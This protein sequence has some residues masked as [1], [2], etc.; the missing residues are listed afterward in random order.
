V[1]RGRVDLAIDGFEI[2]PGIWVGEGAEIDPDAVLTGPLCIGSYAK[3][4]AG[5]Q[6]GEY[7]VLGH[8]VLVNEGALLHRAVVHDNVVIGRQA[9]L[10][11]CVVGKSSD[12]LRAAAVEE[13]VVIGDHCTIEEEA[14]LGNDVKVYPYKTI[15][16][17]AVVQGSVIWESRGQRPLFGRHGVTGLVNVEITP[18][19]CVRIAAAYAT[20]ISKG[21]VV[22]IGR[23]ASRAGRALERAVVGALTAAAIEVRDLETATM[24]LLRYDVRTSAA[25]GGIL[26]RTTAGDPQS[27]DLVFLDE[28]GDDLSAAARGRLERLYSRGEFR[29]AF[30]GEIADV[31]Y[32][33]RTLE[34]YVQ[35]LLERIDVRGVREANPR[36]V[37][38]AA[39]GAVSLV[40][41]TLLGRLDL[42]VLTINGRLD[43]RAVDGS[44]ARRRADLERLGE[45]V[46]SSHAAF[47]IRF[48]PMGERLTLLDDRGAIVRPDRALLVALDLVAAENRGSR[49]AVPITTTRV[50]EEVC[51]FHGVEVVRTTTSSGDLTRAAAEPRVVFAGDGQD[52]FVVPAFAPALDGLAAFVR[53][54]GLV[55]RTRLTLSG[56]DARI[57]QSSVARR[58]VPTPWAVRGTVMRQVL[59]AASDR[60]V[61]TTDG[62]RISYPDGRWVLVVPDPAEAR[63]TI[64]AEGSDPADST[65]LIE[66]WS[67]V[68]ITAA[69]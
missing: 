57:P 50:A 28:H 3:V 56:I 21:S 40:L 20:T 26:I 58:S 19:L 65:A 15:D 68:V 47:G 27:V 67:R 6:L 39:G 45:L 41:P 36:V 48:D 31:T 14:I 69:A 4:E 34:A 9:S 63:T 46:V 12:V 49:A 13:G 59:G 17:G 30:P 33:A 22:S 32:A 35:E 62:V 10:R 29:R 64:W 2:S 38:D 61:D 24:P 8:N 25:C 23:D 42:D 60:S 51:R 18:E 52:G 53:L 1:L 54:L 55:A 44:V 16:A 43:E 11:G 7:T 37:I 5:A 66:R